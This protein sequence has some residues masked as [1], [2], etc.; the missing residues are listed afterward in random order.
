MIIVRKLKLRKIWRT[1]SNLRRGVCNGQTDG[2]SVITKLVILNKIAFA[3]PN[4]FDI[5]E[6]SSTRLDETPSPSNFV[7]RTLRPNV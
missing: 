1:K 3:L 2:S 7:L 4:I 6:S 5:T